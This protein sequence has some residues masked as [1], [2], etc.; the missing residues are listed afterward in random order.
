MELKTKIFFVVVAL[1]FVAA[2]SQKGTEVLN[3][4]DQRVEFKSTDY[5]FSFEVAAGWTYTEFTGGVE[6]ASG[7]Y[8]DTVGDAAT[9]ALFEKDESD[10]VVLFDYLAEGQ[11][12]TEYVDLRKSDADTTDSM[13]EDGI[14]GIIVNQDAVGSNGGSVSFIYASDGNIVLTLRIEIVVETLEEGTTIAN[15]FIDIINS[16]SF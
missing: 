11:T 13:E 3:P 8:S 6:P 9:V 7:V 14:Q 12:L 4:E 16:V 2:C 1:L 10:F 15:E 5:G